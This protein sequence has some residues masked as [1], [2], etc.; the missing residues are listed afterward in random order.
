M[1]NFRDWLIEQGYM[2]DESGA[3]MK[4]GFYCSGKELFKKLEEYKKLRS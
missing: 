4:N 3:W 1:K 2:T